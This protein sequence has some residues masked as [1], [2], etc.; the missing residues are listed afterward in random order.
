[1]HKETQFDP[2]VAHHPDGRA[3]TVETMTE[4]LSAPGSHF[5][6]GDVL[7]IRVKGRPQGLAP[8]ERDR[9]GV[10]LAY[11]EVTGHSHQLR[12]AQVTMYRDGAGGHEYLSVKTA[13]S[14]VH[15]EHGAAPVPVGDFELGQ[16]VRYEPT[17]LIREAD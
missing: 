15:E 13:D 7:A 3:A 17:R 11:G 9:G 16:Q 6:Q 2:G 1:M 10:V 8:V 4:A 14:L 12:G 5:R